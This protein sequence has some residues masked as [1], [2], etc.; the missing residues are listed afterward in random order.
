MSLNRST[1]RNEKKL[2]FTPRKPT[3]KFSS[4]SITEEKLPKRQVSR[5]LTSII[6]TDSTNITNFRTA[7]KG[8]K[9]R[10]IRTGSSMSMRTSNS[11]SKRRSLFNVS[12]KKE[13]QEIKSTFKEMLFGKNVHD[14]D[15]QPKVLFE[16][17]YNDDIRGNEL[18]KFYQNKAKSKWNFISNQILKS[19]KSKFRSFLKTVNNNLYSKLSNL[20]KHYYYHEFENSPSRVDFIT[21]ANNADIKAVKKSLG[22]RKL[23]SVHLSTGLTM[24]A[25]KVNTRRC[26]NKVASILSN[27]KDSTQPE[28]LISP[29]VSISRGIQESQRRRSVAGP[30]SRRYIALSTQSVQNYVPFSSFIDPNNIENTFK[31]MQEGSR[32]SVQLT[33]TRE[34]KV[35]RSTFNIPLVSKPTSRSSQR[36]PKHEESVKLRSQASTK[37][38]TTKRVSST[39]KRHKSGFYIVKNKSHNAKAKPV[40]PKDKLVLFKNRTGE[41]KFNE[42]SSWYQI[43]N[44][45]VTLLTPLV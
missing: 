3:S 35:F 39:E 6:V 26:K 36:I 17:S 33:R 19:D 45:S 44:F 5:K 12:D 7:Y 32:K 21:D 27:N 38:E 42:V 31:N 34:A 28:S 13:K 37:A 1:T 16:D 23:R 40:I 8:S 18:E 2:M 22:R 30:S 24:L 9:S 11:K 15:Y 10:T 43:G 14:V 25:S 20:G 4:S 41:N 29:L